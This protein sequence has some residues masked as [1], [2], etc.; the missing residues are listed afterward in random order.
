MNF[1]TNMA[2]LF[3]FLLEWLH[4]MIVGVAFGGYPLLD[5]GLDSRNG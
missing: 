3:H 4:G 2:I 5:T 1:G